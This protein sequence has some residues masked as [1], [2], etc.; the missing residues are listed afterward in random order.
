ML[1]AEGY[2]GVDVHRGARVAVLAH[3]RQIV[4][5]PTTAALLDGETLL[6]LGSHRL[7]DFEGTTRLRQLGAG[8]FPPLRTPGSVDLPPRPHAS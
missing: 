3:G 8:A 2:V 5:S 6:D 7:A 4:V 1:A